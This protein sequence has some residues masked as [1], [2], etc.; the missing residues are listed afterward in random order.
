MLANIS[1]SPLNTGIPWENRHGMQ[2]KVSGLQRSRGSP[3]KASRHSCFLG[4]ETL[5]ELVWEGWELGKEYTKSLVLKNV[6]EKLQKLSF[7][8]PVSKRFTTLFPRTISLSPGMS[9]S[10]P[11]TFHPLQESEHVDSIEFQ[12]KE[13]TFQVNLR[14]VMLHHALELPDSVQLPLCAVQHST[15]SSFLF[16][17]ASKLQT[18]FQ[19]TVE[20]PFHLSPLSGVLKPGEQRRVSVTFKPQQALVY[21]T[22][23][24]CTFGKEGEN[25]CTILLKGLSKY[26]YLQIRSLGQ[27][28]GVGVLEFGSVGIGSFLEKHFEIFN[29]SSVL[30]SFSLTRLKRPAL[31]ESVFECDVQEGQVSPCSVLKVAVRFTPLTVDS[32]SVDYFRLSCPGGISTDVLKVTGSCIGP[33]VTLSSSVVDFGCVEEGEETMR[34]IHIMNSSTVQAYYQFDMDPSNHSV[35]TLDQP[36]GTLPANGSITLRLSFRPYHPIAYHK[37]AACLI[38]HREPLLLDL[39]GTCHSEQLKPDILQPRHLHV[40]RKN[41]LRGL[42]CYPPDILSAM[43]AEHKLHLDESGALLFPKDSSEDTALSSPPLSLGNMMEEY[44]Q[45]NLRTDKTGEHPDENGDLEC[46]PLPHVTVEPSELLFYSGP[47][48]QSVTITNHTKGKLSLLWTPA[49]DSPFSITPLTCDL[50]PLKSTVFIV[51][52]APKQHNVF[53][54]A[55]LECFTLY[56]IL[57]DHQQTEDRTLCPPWCLTVRVTAHSF[58]H[59]NEHFNPCL[60]LQPSH[61]TFP[62]LCQVSYRSIL[63]QNTG[64]LPL[65]FKLTTK[66]CPA[67]S[68][69]PPSGLVPPCSHQILILRSTPAEDNPGTLPLTLQLNASHKHT[70][71]LSMVCV[72]ERP[73]I[74]LEG[75]G[76][77][78]FSPTAV[79]SCSKATLSIRNFSRVALHFHWRVCDSDSSVLSVQPDSG[80]LQPNESQIQTWSFTPLEEMAYNMKPSLIFWPIQKPECKRS[81]L[82]L[83]VVGLSAKGSIQAGHPFLDLG[84]VLVGGCKSFEVPL[85]NPSP[86]AVSFSLTVLQSISAPE[87]SL[88]DPLVLDME[89]MTGIIPAHSRLLIH[90]TVRPTRRARYHWTICYKILNASGLMVGDSCSLCQVEAEGVYPTLEVTDAR[91]SGSVEGLSKLYLWKL[92]C[93]DA[94]N[95]YLLSEPGPAELTYRVPTRHSFHRCPPV[96]TS[97]MLD[98]NFSSAPL[99]A[100]PSNILLMFENTGN[101][102]VEWVFLFPEDQQIE[103]E[104]WAESAELSPT[105]LLQMKVQDNRMFSVSPRSGK[106]QPGQRRAVQ[107]TYR[108]DLFGTYRLPVLLK[109]SHGREILL[110]FIGV[111]VEK[112]KHYLHFP[113]TRHVFAPVAI[114]G[115]HPPKQVYE[116]YNGGAQPVRYRLD[117]LPLQELQE[118]NFNHPVLQCLNPEGDVQPGCTATLEWIFSPLEAKTYSV[119]IPIY[120]LEG[121]SVLVTFEGCGFDKR[122]SVPLQLHDGHL[123]VPCTQKVSLPSQMVFLSEERVSFGDIPVCSR[124]THMLFLT[125]ISHTDRVLYKWNLKEQD[126]KQ[127]VQIHPV[128]GS[129]SAE[130]SVLCILT[131]STSSSP[132]FYQ[133][134]L[135]CEITPEA[136]LA[137]YQI[138]LQ[139][140]EEA[141]EREKHEFTITEK[142]L[143]QT[144]HQNKPTQGERDFNRRAAPQKNST[145]TRKFKALP[146]I[147][148]N[149]AVLEEPTVKAEKKAQEVVGMKQPEP[150]RPKLLHL[151]VTARSHSL[152]EYQ[153]QFPSQFSK[154][155]I[156]RSISSKLPQ[157][158]SVESKLFSSTMP[159]LTHGPEKDIL[160]HT[161]TSVLR[162]L[163]DDPAFHQELQNISTEPVPY[164]TQLR[165]ASPSLPMTPTETSYAKD[166]VCFTDS[167]PSTHYMESTDTVAHARTKSEGE[168][169][170]QPCQEPNPKLRELVQESIRRSPEF[171][172]LMEEILLNTLQ[173]LMTE[174]FLGEL[175]LT[176][177]PRIIA[178]PPCS[179]RRNSKRQSRGHLVCESGTDQQHTLGINPYM[180]SIALLSNLDSQH[181]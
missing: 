103:L 31:M 66:D 139:Q 175:V 96:L 50:S 155:H 97:A 173:N 42:T 24:T 45:M 88:Q 34:I 130:E 151:G 161:L 146:P 169:E 131:I 104:C 75:D 128:S 164:F 174:A 11:I 168:C 61:M 30:T 95:T 152:L 81:R 51:T 73:R 129:L 108:H 147:R 15:N 179:A 125:N 39:I 3:K 99:G 21:Q 6:N 107:F 98:F 78:F 90:S 181:H 22:E 1:R 171:G 93:I 158:G 162:S 126:G 16:R 35:F 29:P 101:I 138:D 37:R 77:L 53:H 27:E 127:A 153:A 163:L 178:L 176:A 100:D 122:D 79:G 28:E 133:Q 154:H 68:V 74:T 41:L 87:G 32:T 117:T 82:S 84:E 55:Q 145:K 109:L 8:P 134:D 5:P 56:K 118:E 132:T 76:S 86:C 13:G 40:Y 67:V 25:T 83:K 124:S 69:L 123:T 144:N 36:A 113:S 110:N 141:K 7:R 167:R 54:A 137:H 142:D 114:G 157:S 59:G 111:T 159:P 14:A 64:D 165:P 119:D 52:Y 62:A 9:F 12:C 120:V 72:A 23:A 180:P 160:T 85:L 140:W 19:W 172:D 38:L 47:S 44:F 71:E 136:A 115:F 57:R 70:Q 33:V 65:I 2:G 10:L 112:D 80:V 43:L 94:L 89:S 18:C 26:P 149:S 116:I 60:C 156:Y 150:P 92:F 58:Q 170:P 48:S 4:V 46:F 49:P 177:R 20:P 148:S 106:L 102:L 91:S 63:L 17:N 121:D 166:P 135:I 105:E 143:I